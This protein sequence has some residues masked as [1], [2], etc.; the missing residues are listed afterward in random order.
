MR[1]KLLADDRERPN[2]PDPTLVRYF[3][4]SV[5]GGDSRRKRMYGLKSHT[6]HYYSNVNAAS[7]STTSRFNAADEAQ[8]KE[9]QDQTSANTVDIHNLWVVNTLKDRVT[10]LLDMTNELREIVDDVSNEHI[11][12][13]KTN[14]K[15]LVSSHSSDLYFDSLDYDKSLDDRDA[16]VN[17]DFLLK[18]QYRIT[19]I[20]GSSD[21][22][23]CLADDRSGRLFL[24][25]QYCKTLPLP[26]TL[27]CR[28]HFV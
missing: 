26:L 25:I 4:G 19:T 5:G 21:G 24:W 14:Q 27:P 11:K 23:V 10:S 8:L 3:E 6:S 13:Q 18:T 15:V 1:K 20:V 28:R 9:V 2:R 7:S 12:T 16:F 22:M 17:L